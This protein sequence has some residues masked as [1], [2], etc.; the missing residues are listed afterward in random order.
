MAGSSKRRGAV[1]KPGTKKGPQ[2]GSGGQRRRGLEGRGPTP[3]ATERTG[4]PAAARK[5]AAE[6]RKAEAERRRSTRR[7]PAVSGELVAGRNAV[8]EAVRAGTPVEK[9]FLAARAESDDRLGEVLLAVTA[10]H[11]PL[12]EATKGE[13]DRLT[14]GANHQGIAVQ[15]PPYEYAD[16]ADLLT[17]AE[18]RPPLIVALDGVTDPHNLGA[19][20]R[21]AG[22]FGVD[23]VV[24]PERR[25]AGVTATVWKVSAGAA[26]RVPVARATNL[27]R[28]LQEYQKAGCFVVG[29]DGRAPTSVADLELAT[30]PLVVVVGSEG[31]G[32]SRLVRETCDLLA[33]IEISSQVESLNAAVATGIT[34]YEVARLRA[35]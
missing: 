5:A 9:V 23:G 32:L 19:V 7:P 29:L 3:K 16:P 13:L 34:L 27:V 17:R 2:V 1:R 6:K 12:V 20:L 8:L 15:V 28:T 14:D 33:G 18:G 22:A 35:R 4:H 25:S 11:L 21:S 26:A 30:E 31:K 24:V 10:R